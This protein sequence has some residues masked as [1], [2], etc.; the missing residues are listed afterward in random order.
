MLWCVHVVRA[1]RSERQPHRTLLKIAGYILG[2]FGHTIAETEGSRAEDQLRALHEHFLQVRPCPAGVGAVPSPSTLLFPHFFSGLSVHG[3]HLAACPN[4]MHRDG[5]LATPVVSRLSRT[6]RRC[7]S[8]RM[9]SSPMPMAKSRA[10]LAT[11]CARLRPRWTKRFSSVQWSI[12]LWVA[13]IWSASRA[14]Y[15]CARHRLVALSS[16]RTSRPTATPNCLFM[17]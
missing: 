8:T 11:C 15:V 9:R 3:T 7:C 6:R 16:N 13:P 4:S 10:R 2:E 14:R 1:T 5:T 12:W 17:V